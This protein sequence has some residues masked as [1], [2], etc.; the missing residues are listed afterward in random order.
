[1]PAFTPADDMSY[2][3]CN[4]GFFHKVLITTQGFFEFHIYQS[5]HYVASGVMLRAHWALALI[6]V[7]FVFFSQHNAL[8]LIYRTDIPGYLVAASLVF[9]VGISMSLPV[10]AFFPKPAVSVQY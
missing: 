7:S 8:D 6:A 1:M 10:I 4:A 9:D 2:S 3:F 5:S